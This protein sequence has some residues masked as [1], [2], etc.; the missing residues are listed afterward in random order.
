MHNPE[1]AIENETLK[2]LWDFKIQ[3][4]HLISARRPGLVIVNNKKKRESAD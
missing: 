3:T 2:I 1:S 4:V